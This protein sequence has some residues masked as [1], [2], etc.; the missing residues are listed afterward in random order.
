MR[1]R[2]RLTG[3]VVFLLLAAT[4]HLAATTW[5]GKE[6]KCPVCGTVNQFR[7]PMSFG[8]Y[9]FL[10][11][12]KFQVIFWPH[13]DSNVLH[14]CK[15]CHFTAFM[16]DF[17]RVPEEKLGALRVTLSTVELEASEDYARIPM[18]ARLAVAEKAYSVLERDDEFW[19][20]FYRV[21]AYHSENEGKDDE[22][23][24]AR[25]K[26]LELAQNMLREPGKQGRRKELLVIAA[27][28]HH[29]LEED[30]E[31]LVRLREAAGLKMQHPEM[32]EEQN[33]NA[34]QYFSDLIRE[35]IE[36]LEKGEPIP[37]SKPTH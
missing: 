9:I 28:M 7:T 3:F 1:N 14:S 23:A 24:A 4:L 35:Y 8:G 25:R 29:F 22:A 2:P 18:T 31:A 26:A 32:T 10:W 36:K 11:P 5:A 20:H 37:D 34:D 33:E 15:K 30:D 13:I 27:A 19:C 16:Y 17:P 21:V 6:V 12:S